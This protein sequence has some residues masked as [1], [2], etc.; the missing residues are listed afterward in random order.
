MT[1]RIVEKNGKKYVEMVM[2]DWSD[3]AMIYGW[4]KKPYIKR[5]SEKMYLSDEILSGAT[6]TY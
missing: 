2:G 1:M 6:L 4:G 3:Y 5:L